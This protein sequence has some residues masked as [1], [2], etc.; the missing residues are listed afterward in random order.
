MKII[1]TPHAEEQ[2]VFR[3]L[4]R[5][6]VIE[7]ATNPQQIVAASL[8]RSVAQSRYQVQG[9]EYLLRVLIEDRTEERWVITV[10]PTSKISKYWRGAA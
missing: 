2:I 8:G 9:K 7:V 3:K 4:S 5:E 6:R 1:I 10:Y